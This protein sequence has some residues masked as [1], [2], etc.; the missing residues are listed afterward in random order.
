VT[1]F[2]DTLAASARIARELRS[3]GLNVDCSVQPNRSLGDQLRYANRKGV[4]FAVIAGS[5]ELDRGEAA[6]KDLASGEQTTVPL[7]R[8][9]EEMRSRSA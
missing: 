7:A 4:R 6:L 8:L 2:P 1:V 5:A 3:A 9:A